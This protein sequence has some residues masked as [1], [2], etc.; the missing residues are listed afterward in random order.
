M[1]HVYSF[2]VLFGFYCRNLRIFEKYFIAELK[3]CSK[4]KSKVIVIT[5]GCNKEHLEISDRSSVV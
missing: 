1:T 4:F 2:L 3:K 5:S